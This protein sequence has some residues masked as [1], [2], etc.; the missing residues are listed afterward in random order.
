MEKKILKTE[1][2]LPV[3]QF[4]E[5]FENVSQKKKKPEKKNNLPERLAALLI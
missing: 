4:P 2:N 5:I 3:D 1:N